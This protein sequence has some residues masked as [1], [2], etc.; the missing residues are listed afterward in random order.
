MRGTIELDCPEEMLLGLHVS[1]EEF[2]EEV[3]LR[4]AVAL[5]REGRMSSGMAARWLKVPRVKFLLLAMEQ[6]GELLADTQDDFH[7]ETALL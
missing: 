7:R 5:F 4:A 3:K 1:A 2:R 6:G